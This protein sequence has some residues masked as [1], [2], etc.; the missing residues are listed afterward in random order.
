MSEVEIDG[1]GTAINSLPAE[2]EADP[3]PDR[4]LELYLIVRRFA[5]V[6]T[7]DCGPLDRRTMSGR[8]LP[9]VGRGSPDVES[10]PAGEG[11]A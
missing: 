11:R 5:E 10:I 4:A 1:L 3:T 2:D 6:C 8:I 9:L 7:S